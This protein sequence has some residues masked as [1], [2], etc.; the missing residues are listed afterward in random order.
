ML[1]ILAN[2]LLAF[3]CLHC[4]QPH[5]LDLMQV[6]IG[7]ALELLELELELGLGLGLGLGLEG[8]RIPSSVVSASSA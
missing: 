3:T 7:L 4:S 5:L 1:R 2:V 8:W 6:R